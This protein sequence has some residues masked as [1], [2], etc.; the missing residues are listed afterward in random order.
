[1]RAFFICACLPSDSSFWLPAGL[2]GALGYRNPLIG[3]ELFRPCRATGKA[4]ALASLVDGG[5]LRFARRDLGDPDRRADHVG[6]ALLSL[7][8]LRHLRPAH[9]SESYRRRGRRKEEWSGEIPLQLGR[10]SSRR[11]NQTTDAGG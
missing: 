4:A 2:C 6:G 10:S 3:I 1:M 9:R 8:A 5:F 7:R 11:R